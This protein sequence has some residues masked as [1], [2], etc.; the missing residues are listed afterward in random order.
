VSKNIEELPQDLLELRRRLETL[1]AEQRSELV[2]LCDRV[3][4][5]CRLHHRMINIAQEALLQLRLDI[6]Y[7]AFDL[8]ATRRERDAFRKQLEEL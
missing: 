5:V 3:T 7:L 4:Q 1:P 6:K 8:E 2:P